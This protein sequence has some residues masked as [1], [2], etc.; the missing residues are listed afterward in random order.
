MTPSLAD[1]VAEEV[2]DTEATLK[3]GGSAS[4]EEPVPVTPS[5]ADGVVVGAR[6]LVKEGT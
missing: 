2:K 3:G 1:G 5:L 6:V 4:P